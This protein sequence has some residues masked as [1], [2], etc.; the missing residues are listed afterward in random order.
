MGGIYCRD[1][2]CYNMALKVALC[3]VLVGV[4]LGFPQ[5]YDY[6]PPAPQT[7]YEAPA[8]SAESEEVAE[9]VQ[10]PV[11]LYEAPIVADEQNIEPVVVPAPTEA[12]AMLMPYAFD[13]GV[14]DEESGNEF[15]HV[16]NSDGQVT[17]G[18]YRVLLPDGRTQVVKFFD[19]G[20]GF[21][22]EVTYE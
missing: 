13:F 3:I 5:G 19:D 18:E 9:T 10:E 8:E 21:N 17:Q 6:E 1:T 20:N 22:A 11:V 15:S 16:E 12:P 2:S 7:L 14:A 4:A